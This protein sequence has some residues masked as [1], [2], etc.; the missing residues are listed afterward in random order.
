MENGRSAL[1][2]VIQSRMHRDA[3]NISSCFNSE[4][5]SAMYSKRLCMPAAMEWSEGDNWSLEVDL[6][7]GI[8]DFKCA[9]VRQDG[10]VACWEPGANRTVEVKTS[11]V[12]SRQSTSC[13]LTHDASSHSVCNIRCA[14][15]RLFIAAMASLQTCITPKLKVQQH[16][17]QFVPKTPQI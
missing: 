17:Q 1:L 16:A 10:S 5:S 12:A 2:Q 14:C 6:F 13:F 15:C 11:A 7:P 3:G 4:P 8:T 9:V